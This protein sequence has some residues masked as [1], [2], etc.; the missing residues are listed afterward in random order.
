[1]SF[2]W[3]E[4]LYWLSFQSCKP[5]SKILSQW[6]IQD[7]QIGRLVNQVNLLRCSRYVVHPK[8][9]DARV[10]PFRFKYSSAHVKSFVCARVSNMRLVTDTNV[11]W[12]QIPDMLQILICHKCPYVTNV[13]M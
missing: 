12:L 2:K 9:L 11:R 5:R 3:V 1:M 10:Y 13:H 6:V 7:F 4:P 8:S